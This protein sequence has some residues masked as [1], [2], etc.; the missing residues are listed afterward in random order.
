MPSYLNSMLDNTT[1]RF[2]LDPSGTGSHS[3]GDAKLLMDQAARIVAALS[4]ALSAGSYSGPV[5]A[6]FGLCWD[7]EG[8]LVVVKGSGGAHVQV[9]LQLNMS[10]DP[11]K[12][13]PKGPLPGKAYGVQP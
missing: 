11:P 4:A 5:E 13:A 9:T 12:L 3:G 1:L 7:D 10:S 6:R 8:A 2:E